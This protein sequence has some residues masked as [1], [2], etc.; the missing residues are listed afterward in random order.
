M[1]RFL[2]CTLL[3]GALAGCLQPPPEPVDT[4]PEPVPLSVPLATG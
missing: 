3:L 1:K 2:V 4:G